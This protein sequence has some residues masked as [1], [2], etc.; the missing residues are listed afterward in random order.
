LI[1]VSCRVSG[2]G[3]MPREP[4]Q[5]PCNSPVQVDLQ[6]DMNGSEP[7]KTV[8][9]SLDGTAYEIDLTSSTPRRSRPT[10][11]PGASPRPYAPAPKSGAPT[12]CD[13]DPAPPAGNTHLT[14]REHAPPPNR[15]IPR[16]S[17]TLGAWCQ[18]MADH[19]EVG[20]RHVAHA[21]YAA[22]GCTSRSAPS[23]L[24]AS[25]LTGD[26]SDEFVK[27][28]GVS[29]VCTVTVSISPTRSPAIIRIGHL[30]RSG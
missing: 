4:V 28:S 13:P 5:H 24:P 10:R 18:V 29:R 9:S 6:H 27:R 11:F 1:A 19:G 22:E 17:V 16:A 20:K 2:A 26:A 21:R 8:H 3:E 15:S 7:A 14:R 25:G 12:S 30:Q 23:R